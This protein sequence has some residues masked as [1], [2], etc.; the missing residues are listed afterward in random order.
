MTRVIN[1]LSGNN[2]TF[3]SSVGNWSLTSGSATI[4][5]TKEQQKLSAF[6]SLKVTPNNASAFTAS[7]TQSISPEYLGWAVKFST[8]LYSP[9]DRTVTISLSVTN[10][11]VAETSTV[12]LRS[13][14]WTLATVI[15]PSATTVYLD[16]GSATCSITA[17]SAATASPLYVSAPVISTPDSIVYNTFNN[18]M[19]FRLPEYLRDNDPLDATLERPLLRFLDIA[20]MEAADLWD[21]WESIRYI[22]AD[23]YGIAEETS[24]LVDPEKASVSWLYWLAMIL[25]F[26][27]QTS[28][29]GVSSWASL[30]TALDTNTDGSLTWTELLGVDN[31]ATWTELESQAPNNAGSEVELRWQVASGVYGINAGTKQ[32]IIDAAQHILTGTKQ[33]AINSNYGGDPW[34]FEVVTITSETP[35]VVGGS[36]PTLLEVIAPALPIGY[37]AV[38][39][40]VSAGELV[41]EQAVL[42][43]DAKYSTAG[44]TTMVNRGTAGQALNASYGSG[45]SAPV[46]LPHTGTNYLHFPG[47]TSN[48]AVIAD[49]TPLDVVGPID[50]LCRVAPSSWTTTYRIMLAKWGASPNQSFSFYINTAGQLATNLSPNG[51]STITPTSTTFV[52]PAA[53][54]PYWLRVAVDTTAQQV[55]YYAAPD[56]TTEPASWTW[57][58]TISAA[59][60]STIAMGTASLEIGS[61][62]NSSPFSGAIYRTIL[63]SGIGASATVIADC[64]FTKVT[65]AEQHTWGFSGT[66]ASSGNVFSG[67]K[68]L[69]TGGDALNAIIGNQPIVE[70]YDP[71]WLRHTGTN[72]LYIGSTAGSHASIPN[73]ASFVPTTSISYR[74]AL[75]L[76]DWTPSSITYLGGHYESANGSR[77]SL[78][79]I[80]TSGTPFMQLSSDGTAAT[81]PTAAS[82]F[83]FTDGTLRAV[84][85]DWSSTGPTVR[86]FTKS[87]TESTAYADCE[88]DTGWTQF[89]A[90]ITAL[91][92]ASLFTPAAPLYVAGFSS[93]VTGAKYY[94]TVVKT[95]GVTRAAVN[96]TTGITSGAQ[97]SFTESSANAATVTI[98]RGTGYKAVAVTRSCWLFG[99]TDT[100]RFR[101]HSL[102]KFDTSQSFTAVNFVR[103][104]GATRTPINAFMI[105][106]RSTTS[107]TVGWSLN[108]N[109]TS[110][111]DLAVCQSINGTFITSDGTGASAAPVS[112]AGVLTTKGIVLNRSQGLMYS[113]NASAMAAKSASAITSLEYNVNIEISVGSTAA[114]TPGTGAD[115]ELFGT[116][117]W[118]TALSASQLQSLNDHYNG[119]ITSESTALL[120][121]AVAWIDA[122]LSAPMG[123]IVRGSSVGSP[124]MSVV[125]RPILRFANSQFLS[126][127]DNAII[128]FGQ[129]ETFTVIVAVRNWST[130]AATW[131]GK[132]SFT[133]ASVGWMLRS[134]SGTVESAFVASDGT[135]TGATIYPTWGLGETAVIAGVV[136]RSTAQMFST[137]NSKVGTGVSITYGDIATNVPL[138]IGSVGGVSMDSE[139]LGAAIFAGTLTTQQMSD[140]VTYFR[141]SL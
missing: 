77:S 124:R 105:S 94:A 30:V 61:Q 98:T 102:L 25:G 18:E 141:S 68:N 110:Y 132:R 67:I 64:D 106:G 56:Q 57:T 126:V 36:S 119:T 43:L 116:A 140:V 3:D 60:A 114:G 22:P 21:F 136:D 8:W 123:A 108:S 86:I 139:F 93:G 135:N 70:Q 15:Q 28:A 16:V 117:I 83:G 14:V 38:H 59:G 113:T 27:F 12:F 1:F 101:S 134:S 33:V 127:A 88:S 89:G 4:S 19:Y 48:Y 69:G 20:F 23:E 120:Q 130:N 133:G 72:Y 35:D 29:S 37:S 96:F 5:V 121:S 129:T 95:D 73:N 62:N 122:G 50:I 9:I 111:Q 115:M 118:D 40:C 2:A 91:V 97:T 52:A 55:T 75:T 112:S 10:D 103:Q 45:A 44:E 78:C 128:D 84:R 79:A 76:D 6:G 138:L 47:L 24:A 82:A 90:D 71:I 65:T 74:F 11:P 49:N 13:G 131:I 80:S 66:A 99:A 34:V 109:S 81:S 17:A 58:Q 104:W 125:T 107:P 32:A 7:V 51:T 46:V 63:K 92:P 85:Y 54:T 87:T 39:R 26:K 53:N 100:I 31:T 42:W 41:L 137:L